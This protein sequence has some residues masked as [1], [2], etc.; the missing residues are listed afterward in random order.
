MAEFGF[1]GVFVVTFTQTPRLKGA[2]KNIGR[3]LIVLK[4]RVKAIDFD[5][6]LNLARCDFVSWFIVGIVISLQL[7]VKS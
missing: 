3:F 6:R 4:V 5:L 7:L 1:F 2:G